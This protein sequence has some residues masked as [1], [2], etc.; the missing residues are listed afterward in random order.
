[1]FSLNVLTLLAA[2]WRSTTVAFPNYVRLCR[3]PRP[4]AAKVLLVMLFRTVI[5]KVR[6]VFMCCQ[7]LCDARAHLTSVVSTHI[8]RT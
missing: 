7:R 5:I 6:L 2:V 3:T 8:V 1:M 4:V